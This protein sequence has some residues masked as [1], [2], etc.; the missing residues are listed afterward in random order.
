VFKKS[1]L[2]LVPPV[3]R[4]VPIPGRDERCILPSDIYNRKDVELIYSF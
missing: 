3:I 1:G 4:K 2:D